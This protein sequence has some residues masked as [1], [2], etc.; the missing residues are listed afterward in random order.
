LTDRKVTGSLSGMEND[1]LADRASAE[2]ELATLAAQRAALAERA[3]QP[4]WYDVLL[5]LLLFAFIGSYSLRN[6]WL[7]LAA[8]VVF[9]LCLRG[10]VA[11]YR[12][13][14]G[15]WVHGFRKGRT[16]KA[17]RAWFGCVLVVLGA[18]FT[19]ELAFDVRGAMVVAGAVLAVALVL[20]NR[21]WS[22]IYVAELRGER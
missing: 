14:T 11:L 8:V 6:N 3:M 1:A 10:M 2:A 21:W 4:W 12:R 19:A 16:Q 7:T 15:F 9:L 20:V 13:H 5:A 18:G 17:I 22:R